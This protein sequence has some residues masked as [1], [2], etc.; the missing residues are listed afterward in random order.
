MSDTSPV[1]IRHGDYM[2]I[3]QNHFESNIQGTNGAFYFGGAITIEEALGLN[4]ITIQ[5]NT[6]TKYTG[7]SFDSSAYNFY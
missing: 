3:Y 1:I 2:K 7:A 4:G 6:I 5:L